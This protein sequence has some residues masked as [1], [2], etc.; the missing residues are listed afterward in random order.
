MPL[1]KTQLIIIVVVIAIILIFLMRFAIYRYTGW[2]TFS[3]K[4]GE[5]FQI[6]NTNDPSLSG[7]LKFRDCIYTISGNDNT[8]K[9]YD[10]TYALNALKSAYVNNTNQNYIFK[11]DD[12]GLSVYSFQ[13]PGFND[14]TNHPNTSNWSDFN[15]TTKITLTGYYKLLN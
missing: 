5:N 11:L 1:S 6:I 15:P 3:M 12:P 13:L 10:V 7:K 4:K 2:K 8:T 14:K 9:K